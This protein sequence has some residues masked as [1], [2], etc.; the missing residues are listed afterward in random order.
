MDS[1]QQNQLVKIKQVKNLIKTTLQQNLKKTKTFLEKIYVD[2]KF[3]KA[4]EKLEK[5]K[6]KLTKF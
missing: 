1:K 2:K 4:K 6:I 3:N 5:T